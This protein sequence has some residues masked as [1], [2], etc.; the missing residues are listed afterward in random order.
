MLRYNGQRKVF[1]QSSIS[2]YILSCE[3]F[4]RTENSTVCVFTRGKQF[5]ITHLIPET[6]HILW[7]LILLSCLT[8]F[9]C[10][11][12]SSSASYVRHCTCTLFS[13]HFSLSLILL[14][15]NSVEFR[16]CRYLYSDFDDL[17]GLWLHKTDVLCNSLWI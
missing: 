8:S 7:K 15:L 17:Q 9:I 6:D 5:G 13:F 10:S 11:L 1:V 2:L 3:E 4:I 16:L 14:L 12:L